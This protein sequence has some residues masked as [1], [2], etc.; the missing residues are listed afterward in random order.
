MRCAISFEIIAAIE[1]VHR[2]AAREITIPF[3]DLATMNEGVP[4]VSFTI[5]IITIILGSMTVLRGL[6]WIHEAGSGEQIS[7]TCVGISHA[8]FC[9]HCHYLYL[10]RPPVSDCYHHPAAD[11]YNGAKSDL[12]CVSLQMSLNQHRFFDGISLRENAAQFSKLFIKKDSKMYSIWGKIFCR[13]SHSSVFY[14]RVLLIPYIMNFNI[15]Y[16]HIDCLYLMST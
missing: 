16:I 15:L 13:I 10:K 1:S 6:I 8:C 3:R 14:I 7:E 4:W 9:V 5:I 11:S 2:H 12:P